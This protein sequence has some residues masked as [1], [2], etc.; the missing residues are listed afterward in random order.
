VDALA[1][2]MLKVLE[3]DGLRQ[4][5]IARGYRRRNALSWERAAEETMAVY[6][7]CLTG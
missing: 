7:R 1:E 4:G 2:A 3:D 6:Q 5:L